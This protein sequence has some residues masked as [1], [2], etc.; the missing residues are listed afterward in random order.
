[1]QLIIGADDHVLEKVW[2]PRVRAIATEDGRM[3]RVH[4]EKEKSA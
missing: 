2:G 4:A 1:M 3:P